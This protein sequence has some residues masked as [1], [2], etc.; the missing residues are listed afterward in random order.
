MTNTATIASGG[1]L[2]AATPAQKRVFWAAW[3]GWM[4]DGFDLSIY[5]FV[6]VP[7]LREL[8][9]LSGYEVTPGNIALYGGYL[10]TAF[11][12]GW[13]SSMFWGWLADRV[14]RVKVL[15]LTILTYS[16]CTALCGFATSILM[17]AIF[18]FLS[19]FGVGGEWAAGTPLLQESVPEHVRA[20]WSGWLHTAIPVGMMLAAGASLLLPIIGWRGMFFIGILPALLTIYLRLKIPE[21]ESWQ[22]KKADPDQ[23]GVRDLFLGTGARNTWSAALMMSCVIVGI[24]SSTFWVPTLIISKMTAMGQPIAEAQRLAS[25]SGFLTNFGTLAGC[26]GM[27]YFA[28][29]IG[30]RKATARASTTCT[31]ITT[32]TSTSCS[33]V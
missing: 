8:L 11:M 17:F 5:F 32:T 31:T 33:T 9:Q 26:L 12:V 10:F 25:L 24:W 3:A 2:A 22:R 19:G 23:M 30:S 1:I 4:L 6:L 14:G 21:P 7:A 28:N 15:C 18:R 29:W 20:K 16:I 27:P 13:A